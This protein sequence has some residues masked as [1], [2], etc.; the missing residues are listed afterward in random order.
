MTS[1]EPELIAD[2]ACH[3]GENPL[4]HPVERKLYWCDIPAGR[5]FRYDPLANQHEQIY[6]GRP[7]GGFSFQAE[8]ALLLFQ[9]CGTM[10]SADHKG[11]LYRLDVD[12]TLHRVLDGIGCANGMAFTQDRKGFYFTD[13]FAHSIYRFDYDVMDGSISNRRVFAKFAE[14]D[15]FP[16]GATL[17]S[18]DHLW[19]ALWDGGCVV[20]LAADGAIAQ[21]YPVPA[22]KAASLAFGGEGYRDLY[23]STAGANQRELDGPLAGALFRLATGHRGLPEYFSRVVE[24]SIS[25]I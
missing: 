3:T 24:G 12:G 21:R 20:R 9:D 22:R 19:S 23:V 10:S 16:D 1:S 11:R 14:S 17:D 5:I 2:Y 13:S 7:V 25:C 18:D 4:W 15:G 8:G 6:D